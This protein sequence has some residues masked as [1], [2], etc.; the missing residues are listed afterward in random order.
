VSTKKDALLTRGA[1]LS[2][3]TLEYI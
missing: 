1:K 3:H 2:R